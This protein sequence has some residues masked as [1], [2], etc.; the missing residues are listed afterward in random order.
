MLFHSSFIVLTELFLVCVT[1]KIDGCIECAL[2]KLCNG[3]Q[4][5]GC[6][7][8]EKNVYQENIQR[9][10]NELQEKVDHAI[11]QIIQQQH[12]VNDLIESN[13]DIDIRLFKWEVNLIKPTSQPT[14]SLQSVPQRSTGGLPSPNSNS[15]GRNNENGM[16]DI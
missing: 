8:V 10:K 13:P 5:I 6:N 12:E 11:A 9:K 14:E 16:F 7:F 1:H 2:R 3:Q 4:R 15:Q